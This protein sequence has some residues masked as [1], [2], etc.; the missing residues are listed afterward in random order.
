MLGRQLFKSWND[1]WQVAVTVRKTKEETIDYRSVD[2]CQVYEGMDLTR[3]TDWEHVIQHFRPQAVINAA[4]VIKQ[5]LQKSDT[6][7]CHYI[8]GVFPHRMQS[9]CEKYNAKF[10]Q[11][12]TDCVFKGDRGNYR[13]TDPI[14]CFDLYS[15]SKA[16][17]EV[18]HSSGLT[19]RSS[20]IGLEASTQKSLIEWFLSQHG[21]IKGFTG[22]IYSG[23]TTLEM[24]NIIE[25][26]LINYFD[27][28]GL[29][30][31]SS[32]PI[33]KYHLLQ[34]LKELLNLHQVG[35]V[36]DSTFQCNRSLCSE[37][38]QQH[39]H[40]TPPSWEQMLQG[41]ADQIKKREQNN[42]VGKIA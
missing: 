1:R 29:Y 36:P 12:S 3:E 15:T 17:G 32:V 25:N 11:I 21:T 10:I 38:F 42:A 14:D 33:S 9:L 7:Q 16:A 24:A 6:Q 40:F 37:R 5:K 2:R 34:Q 23:F 28:T 13:E 20:I 8:N 27:L 18:T 26:V 19:L 41:L 22:A 35:I 39:T 4:G 30:H 31:V